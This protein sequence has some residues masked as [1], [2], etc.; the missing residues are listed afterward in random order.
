MILQALKKWSFWGP[1]GQKRTRFDFSSQISSQFPCQ[2]LVS[3]Q[4]S[5]VFSTFFVKFS[6]KYPP[7]ASQIQFQPFPI[8]LGHFQVFYDHFKTKI[9]SRFFW[10]RLFQSNFKAKYSLKFI[11]DIL[12]IF[13]IK[14]FCQAKFWFFLCCFNPWARQASKEFFSVS[15]YQNFKRHSAIIFQPLRPPVLVPLPNFQSLQ[16][17]IEIHRWFFANFQKLFCQAI[18]DFCFM[19]GPKPFRHPKIFRI[20]RHQNF[21]RKFKLCL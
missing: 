9:R 14:L 8:H 1:K 5:S 13:S 6:T 15:R 17:F 21:V 4:F 7:N 12:P 10:P 3:D 11:D 19:L 18:F 2:I 20:S 16:I